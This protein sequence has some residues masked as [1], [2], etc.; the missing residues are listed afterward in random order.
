MKKILFALI[1]LVAQMAFSQVTTNDI[2]TGQVRIQTRVKQG[3]SQMIPADTLIK[4]MREQAL[5]VVVKSAFN[6]GGRVTYGSVRK[7]TVTIA[8]SMNGVWDGSKYVRN[9]ME[10]VVNN[11][12]VV[13]SD[14]D[15]A[16]EPSGG[17][18][19]AL[20]DYIVF[21]HPATGNIYFSAAWEASGS[22]LYPV[23]G[24]RGYIKYLSK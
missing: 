2:K 14:Y 21:F 4:A 3:F 16:S 19:S 13:V 5:G 7:T 15:Y 22:T 24:S 11:K 23:D 20:N 1:F 6:Y 9:S 10:L 12:I 18:L 17:M 8:P